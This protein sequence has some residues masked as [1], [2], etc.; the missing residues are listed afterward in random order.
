MLFVTNREPK[1]SILIRKNRPFKFEP[2]KKCAIEFNILL[3]EAR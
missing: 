2:E 3:R 1:G